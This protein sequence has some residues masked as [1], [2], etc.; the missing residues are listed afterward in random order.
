LSGWW[1]AAFVS[2]W[3]VVTAV[4]VIVLGFLRRVTAVLERAELAVTSGQINLGA[5]RAGMQ[6]EP[7][8]VFDV[9]GRNI[10]SDE[11]FAVPAT[12][13]LLHSGCEPC[14]HLVGR[15]GQL[16]ADQPVIAILDDS[17]ASHDIELPPHVIRL[18]ERDGSVAAAFKSG[19]TPQAFA[20]S[21]GGIVVETLVPASPADIDRLGR[22]LREGGGAAEDHASV[23]HVA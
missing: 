12:Y 2:L 14:R 6:I 18:F 15:L 8:H 17:P 4:A 21:R 20:V 7:F 1:I 16:A 22:V 5:A 13:L 23:A 3:V 11:L 19:G 9:A 10:G